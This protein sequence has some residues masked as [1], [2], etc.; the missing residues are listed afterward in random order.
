MLFSHFYH[1]QSHSMQI[2]GPGTSILHYETNREHSSEILILEIY[3][4]HSV[5]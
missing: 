5:P 4:T 1:F 3:F 2:I